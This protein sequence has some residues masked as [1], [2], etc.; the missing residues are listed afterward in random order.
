MA[1]ARR[2]PSVPKLVLPKSSESLKSSS[3][4]ESRQRKTREALQKLT[5][6]YSVPMSHS[7][8]SL[9]PAEPVGLLSACEA[10]LIA[11]V[12]VNKGKSMEN[13][14]VTEAKRLVRPPLPPKERVREV[15]ATRRAWFRMSTN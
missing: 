4:L 13:G 11:S 14:C 7:T 5:A 3:R 1:G 10:A 9:R 15:A 8:P 12:A 6:L 2:R